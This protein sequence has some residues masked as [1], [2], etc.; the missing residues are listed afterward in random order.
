MTSSSRN[1]VRFVSPFPTIFLQAAQP[2]IFCV[3]Y[4][5]NN[6]CRGGLERER[7]REREREGERERE[8]KQ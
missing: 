5:Y 7:E 4:Y 3:A 2:Y 8:W 6:Y 1:R